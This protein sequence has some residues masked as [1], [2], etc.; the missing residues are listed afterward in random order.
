MYSL[1]NLAADT[2]PGFWFGTVVYPKDR[3]AANVPSA[4]TESY[5]PWLWLRE[6]TPGTAQQSTTA[7]GGA[8]YLYGGSDDVKAKRRITQMDESY[9]LSVY[10]GGSGNG[11]YTFF[12]RTL[13]ALP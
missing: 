7:I 9:F 8:S 5:I 12:V 1:E 13:I 6:I 3:V 11:T 4:A 10:N 2:D